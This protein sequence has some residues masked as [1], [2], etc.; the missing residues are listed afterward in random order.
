VG[1]PNSVYKPKRF[2]G[3]R[4]FGDYLLRGRR[5]NIEITFHLVRNPEIKIGEVDH[6][7]RCGFVLTHRRYFL[8]KFDF[9]GRGGNS[10][11]EIN[12]F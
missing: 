9:I 7:N 5:A 4:P 6:A 8:R 10:G 2:L 1:K 11:R 12:I 3:V